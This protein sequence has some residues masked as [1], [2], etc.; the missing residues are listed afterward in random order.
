MLVKVNPR[1]KREMICEDTDESESQ[2]R[3]EIENYKTLVEIPGKSREAGECESQIPV[4]SSDCS[5]GLNRVES[6]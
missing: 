3:E 2:V 1:S 5:D 6:L 4:M